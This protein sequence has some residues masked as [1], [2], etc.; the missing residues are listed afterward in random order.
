MPLALLLL[1]AQAATAAAGP[2]QPTAAPSGRFS[3]LTD[4]CANASN[5]GGDVVVCGKPDALAPR[6]PM[7]Q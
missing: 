6:L 4:P 2:P 5:D 1:L 7:P 3:I